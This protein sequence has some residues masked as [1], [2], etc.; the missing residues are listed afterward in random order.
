MTLE[1][2]EFV[3]QLSVGHHPVIKSQTHYPLPQ[4]ARY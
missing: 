4:A 1:F 2:H 3:S